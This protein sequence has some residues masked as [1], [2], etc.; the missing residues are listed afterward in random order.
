MSHRIDTWHVGCGLAPDKRIKLLN[1]DVACP[2]E[3]FVVYFLCSLD[4]LAKSLWTF[5]FGELA[6]GV[7]DGYGHMSIFRR[8]AKSQ[9]FPKGLLARCIHQMFLAANNVCNLHQIVIHNAGE[10]VRREAVAFLDDKITNLAGSKGDF[11]AYHILHHHRFILR[12]GKTDCHRPAFNA[13][14]FGIFRIREIFRALINET[15]FLRFCLLA[16]SIKLFGRLETVVS[17]VLVEQFLNVFIVDIFSLRLQIRSIVSS[18]FRTFV[19][20]DSKPS[21]IVH[22]LLSGGWCISLL[23]GVFDAENECPARSPGP[24][25]VEQGGP[26]ATYVQITRRRRCKTRYDFLHHSLQFLI[27]GSPGCENI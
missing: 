24:E 12:D 3:L 8:L 9:S 26:G 14:L 16:L 11:A 7:T 15:H 13:G 1:A 19:P 4:C 23:V 18:G 21:Q 6:A 17:T 10:V 22:D 27:P 25:P 20:V 5:A 2:G